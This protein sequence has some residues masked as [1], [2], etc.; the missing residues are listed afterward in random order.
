MTKDETAKTYGD[1]DWLK[2]QSA[3]LRRSDAEIANI[4]GISSKA[5]QYWRHKY[6]IPAVKKEFPDNLALIHLVKDLYLTDKKIGEIY[7]CHKAS[8]ARLRHKFHIN[9]ATRM[10]TKEEIY[11]LYHNKLMTYSQIAKKF[12]VTTSA[13]CA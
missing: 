13:V 9:R 11:L 12:G 1:R 5:I 2:R 10:P 4:F 3:V 8:I 6:N 7:D